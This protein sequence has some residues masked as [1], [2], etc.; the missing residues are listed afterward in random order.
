MLLTMS[1]VNATEN[2][3]DNLQ[4]E[5][6]VLLNDS[7]NYK[8]FNDL[9][10]EI[11]DLNKTEIILNNDYYYQNED[12][13]G[14]IV[15]NRSLTIDGQGHI[16]D[17][18][19]KSKI[20]I[21]KAKNVTLKNIKFINGYAGLGSAGAVLFDVN[22][23][24]NIIN[25]TFINNQAWSGG[26]I[27]FNENSTANIANSRFINNRA[28]DGGAIFQD[29]YSLT[30]IKN[31]VF[32]SN[33]ATIS[34]VSGNGGAILYSLDSGGFVAN[35]SFT[36]N[37]ATR[38]GGAV[39]ILKGSNLTVDYSNFKD[40]GAYYGGAL[41]NM[42][43]SNSSILNSFFENNE[44]QKRGGSIYFTWTH[45]SVFNS[46]FVKN[47]ADYGGAI[48]NYKG[49]N[50]RIDNSSFIQNSATYGGGVYYKDEGKS[51]INNSFF[52]EN[53]ADYGAGVYYLSNETKG[54]VNNALFIRNY[55][56]NS[57]AIYGGNEYNCTII[58][59][60]PNI[61]LNP[62]TYFYKDM[63]YLKIIFKGYMGSVIR[64]TSV[65]VEIA[66]VM[67]SI[68]TINSNGEVNLLLKK[69]LP[70]SY[71]I[72]VSFKGDDNYNDEVIY[73]NLVVKKIPVKIKAN[74][75]KFK[76]K[77][78]H[79]KYSIILKDNT[80]KPI[81]NAKVR[82]IVKKIG[83]KSHKKVKSNKKSKSKKK[84]I[85][86]TNKYGKATFKIKLNKK[87]KFS[88]TMI[89]NGNEYFEKSVKKVKF[90]IIK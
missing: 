60:T 6:Q 47:K 7:N 35:S 20:F 85:V 77:N 75:K 87:G 5:N 12:A 54:S 82:L 83:K 42:D 78:K 4:K 41:Y 72:V 16:I 73:K 76:L 56:I 19:Q 51:S 23:N 53:N 68:A 33:H 31:C 26:A 74:K 18:N 8:S 89:Y 84:N 22:S 1:L 37:R 59:I 86:K 21:I 46:T 67:N 66:G 38:Y 70:G 79:K 45:N 58:K 55:A 27:F 32:Y 80:G 39:S 9:G 69:L 65:N 61:I 29:S 28:G 49:K 24:G 15:I 57:S 88:A 36:N 64:N 43:H 90:I 10:N 34:Q 48:Y 44:A 81:K 62:L 50:N 40:N 14:G 52:L 25:S 71:K 17:G 63:E 11:N 3:T 30:S 2:S 13:D